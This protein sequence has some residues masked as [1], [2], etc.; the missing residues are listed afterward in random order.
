[1]LTDI[2]FRGIH[3]VRMSYVCGW[4]GIWV[5]I[6]TLFARDADGFAPRLH[7]PHIRRTLFGT[8]GGSVHLQRIV[9]L[10]SLRSHQPS[11]SSSLDPT[12]SFLRL[13]EHSDNDD[14]SVKKDFVGFSEVDEMDSRRYGIGDLSQEAQDI[15]NSL[16]A[17]ADQMEPYEEDEMCEDYSAPPHGENSEVL[18]DPET[19]EFSYEDAR[20]FV[21]EMMEKLSADDI[22]IA[23]DRSPYLKTYTLSE[24]KDMWKSTI[25]ECN[26]EVNGK[27]GNYNTDQILGNPQKPNLNGV[28]SLNIDEQDSDDDDYDDWDEF[29]LNQII[30]EI[31]QPNMT[32]KIVDDRK[33]KVKHSNGKLDFG[34]NT[35]SDGSSMG[36]TNYTDNVTEDEL[37]TFITETE[38]KKL[39]LRH[40]IHNLIR[41]PFSYD[42]FDLKEALLVVP[43]DIDDWLSPMDDSILFS[44]NFEE[45]A[46][47]LTAKDDTTR[48]VKRYEEDINGT[49][50]TFVDYEDA[51]VIEEQDIETKYV[52]ELVCLVQIFQNSVALNLYAL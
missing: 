25:R 46:S 45:E 21:Q 15:L 41:K 39:W 43:D 31:S 28:S 12:F 2:N 17:T 40:H 30:D 11:L 9:R 34:L 4:F 35:N 50:I 5:N 27:L 1:M 38:L 14:D 7:Y 47:L 48:I 22:D 3:V 8:L 42:D 13:G 29:E 6:L 51:D 36:G 37:P 26:S 24:L 33:Q 18:F 23:G 16:P 52:T 32:I 19:Q 10:Q 49:K 44:S 20:G